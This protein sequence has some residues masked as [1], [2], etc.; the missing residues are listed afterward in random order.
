MWDGSGCM[1]RVHVHAS[2]GGPY[3]FIRTWIWICTGMGQAFIGMREGPAGPMVTVHGGRRSHTVHVLSA[4]TS[5]SRKFQTLPL[6]WAR[7]CT[8]YVIVHHKGS[9][10]NWG[11]GTEFYATVTSAHI[12]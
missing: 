7:V 8:D 2:T 1:H 12:C 3:A 4:S 6:T 9:R 5:I 11:R 10:A